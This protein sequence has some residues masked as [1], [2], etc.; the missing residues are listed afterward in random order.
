MARV[1][2]FCGKRPVAG[3]KVSHSNIKTRKRWL[4]NIKKMKSQANGETKTVRACTRCV[5]SGCIVRPIKRQPVAA[6]A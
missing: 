6:S 2:D 5:R 1:C 4:P 3:N